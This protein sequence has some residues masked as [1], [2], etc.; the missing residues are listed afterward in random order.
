[1]EALGRAG[2]TITT[3]NHAFGWDAMTL[4]GLALSK[5]GGEP[6]SAI[7][8][9]ESGMF[10]EGV[11]GRYSFASEDHNGRRGFNPTKLSRLWHGRLQPVGQGAQ[12][13]S[14]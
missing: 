6:A 7:K 3:T 1:M 8:G 12:K 10:W 4:C 14:Q 9:L 11:T 13:V 5:G 2:V